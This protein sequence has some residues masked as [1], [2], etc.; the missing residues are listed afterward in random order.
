MTL[1]VHG[2]SRPLLGLPGGVLV[3]QWHIQGVEKGWLP[4][5]VGPE[6]QASHS[7]VCAPLVRG[8]IALALVGSQSRVGV[9]HLQ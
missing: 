7:G 5:S 1:A 2:S 9:R 4:A 8:R 6:P 3:P